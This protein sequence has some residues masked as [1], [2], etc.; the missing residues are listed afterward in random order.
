MKYKL[1]EYV[2]LNHSGMLFNTH[3]GES[4]SVNEL[5]NTILDGFRQNLTL[6]EI[7]KSI[8]DAYQVEK[9]ILHEHMMEFVQYLVFNS[10]A[11][12]VID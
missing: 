7:E 3:T 12:E 6:E 11:L 4:F 9:E 2:A 8:F 5:G 1:M 10:L